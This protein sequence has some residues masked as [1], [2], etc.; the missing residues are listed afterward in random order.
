MEFF[1]QKRVW[2]TGAS[3]GIGEALAYEFARRGAHIIL[4]ARRETELN[5]VAAGCAG[6]ASVAVQP[7][8][9]AD[10]A[11]LP[12][13]AEQV[14]RRF[15][16]VDILVHNGGISQRSLVKDTELAVD[17]RLMDVN[18]FGTVALT[19]AVLPSM[20]RHQLGHIVVVTSVMGKFGAPMRSSY[21]ASKHA[22]HGFFEALRAELAD[23]AIQITMICPGFVKTNISKNALTA[24]GSPQ[25][26]VD[27]TI[28]KG[29]DPARLARKILAAVEAGKREAYFGGKEVL[30]VYLHRFFPGILAKMLPNAKVV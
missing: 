25:G 27:E 29:M 5:R 6:A 18:Y 24:D 7:L 16:K 11:S 2:L 10:H 20:L 15:G 19:R 26:T 30:G 3:S 22:L 4:S 17:K 23:S 12:A 28:A 21:A 14:L 1:K 8:D 13:V 9:L